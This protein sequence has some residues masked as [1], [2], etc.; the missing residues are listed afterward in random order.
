METD[1][2]QSNNQKHLIL[3][4]T[5]IGDDID[6][7]FA[8]ALALCS[9][10]IELLGVTTVFGDTQ[11]RAQLV[12]HLLSVFG[13]E[14]IPVAAGLSIPLQLRHQPSGVPQAAILENYQKIPPLST[15]SGPEL[16]V[17]TALAH[18]GHLTLLCIGPLTNIATALSM[19]PHLFPAIRRI[20]LMGGTSGI[21]FPEWNVR[22]DVLAAQKVLA[23]GIPVMMLGWNVTTRCQLQECDI[24]QLRSHSS[25]QIQLLCQLLVIW[26]Q[27]R[28][29]LHP[30]LPYLHDPLTVVTLCSPELLRFQEMPV[31][32][33]G[34]GLLKGF[35]IPRARNGPI[36][37][38]AVDIDA[39]KARIWI[40]QRL[41]FPLYPQPS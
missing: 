9:P 5:D 12:A 19:E 22:S 21:P 26:Q 14:D 27:H 40:M 28:K 13:C 7:A 3:I 16:I 17:Q 8:L 39:E 37:Q 10:E 41:L 23:A 34:Q 31:R 4:D 25:S 29:R 15:L 2:N 32:I 33:L 20:I 30:R 35:M 6:D 18:A 24:E 38:A 36:V 1:A 11:K